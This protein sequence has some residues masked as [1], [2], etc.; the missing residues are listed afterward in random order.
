MVY[1]RTDLHV[2]V[3]LNH[4][5]EVED[6]LLHDHSLIDVQDSNGD[7]AV[8]LCSK[9]GNISI[10]KVLIEFDCSIGRRN[11]SGHIPIG[12]ARMNGHKDVAKML[13]EH[14]S[15][16]ERIDIENENRKNIKAGEQLIFQR[17]NI[18][19]I[20]S[21][22]LIRKENEAKRFVKIR[23]FVSTLITPDGIAFFIIKDVH[24]LS[25]RV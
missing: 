11:Y 18:E 20:P 19:S 6:I 2:A 4:L 25:M 16:L 15:L 22:A 13:S 3:S 12:I 9:S 8:H 14:Y 10:L 23:F 7:Q 5:E 1:E 21:Q 24:K 17:V